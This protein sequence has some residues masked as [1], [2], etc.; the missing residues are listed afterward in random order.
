MN[1]KLRIAAAIA[2]ARNGMRPR[3]AEPNHNP[4]HVGGSGDDCGGNDRSAGA[5]F[6][7]AAGST[8]GTATI[9]V[10]RDMSVNDLVVALVA[11]AG[12][13]TA[14]LGAA[15]LDCTYCEDVKLSSA[16]AAAFAATA[17]DRP[18]FEIDLPAK[19]DLIITVTLPA[20]VPAGDTVF[21]NV[22]VSGTRGKGCC[23]R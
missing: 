1:A 2:A 20:A 15:T 19:E 12:G 6:S 5:N 16:A 11:T 10:Q 13:D 17:Q 9:T 4:A 8:T 3:I 7:I 14:G 22:T 18:A 21:G 23:N